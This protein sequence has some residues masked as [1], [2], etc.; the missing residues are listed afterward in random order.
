MDRRN[1]LGTVPLSAAALTLRN[2]N[3]VDSRSNSGGTASADS[4][5]PPGVNYFTREKMEQSREYP[6]LAGGYSF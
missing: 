3:A 1:F 4:V 5:L 6:N 2:L